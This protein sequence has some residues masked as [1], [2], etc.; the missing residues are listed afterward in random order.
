MTVAFNDEDHV[1][2]SQKFQS[3][4][5][6]MHFAFSRKPPFIRYHPIASLSD[7][8]C[9]ESTDVAVFPLMFLYPISTNSNVPGLYM[10]GKQCRKDGELADLLKL[11]VKICMG[12]WRN[13][14]GASA[15]LR[16]T[17]GSLV[18]TNT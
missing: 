17:R 12:G 7:P 13:M 2:R 18:L 16:I 15:K 11:S 1:F 9:T 6:G 5:V 4:L 8:E 3:V 10:W 14:P